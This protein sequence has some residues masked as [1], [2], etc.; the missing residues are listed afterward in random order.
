[1]L[2]GHVGE[3]GVCVSGAAADA[4]A[5][6]RLRLEPRDAGERVCVTAMR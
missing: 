6:G 1:M 4:D 2:D 3:A 5:D